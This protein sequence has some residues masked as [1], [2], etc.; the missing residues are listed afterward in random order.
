MKKLSTKEAE[1]AQWKQV[2]SNTLSQARQKMRIT[3]K[4]TKEKFWEGMTALSKKRDLDPVELQKFFNGL[5]KEL[6]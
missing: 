3:A 5:T 2:F 6:R 1:I 4:T